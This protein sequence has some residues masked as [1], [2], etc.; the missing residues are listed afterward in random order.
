MEDD[1]YVQ[2]LLFQVDAAFASTGD[3]SQEARED[4]LL[5]LLKQCIDA[6]PNG[7][8]LMRG[9]TLAFGHR[10]LNHFLRTGKQEDLP[11]IQAE[12]TM[13][14]VKRLQTI[15]RWVATALFNS[16]TQP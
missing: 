14:E 4:K 2:E 5:G 10:K 3:G 13:E 16:G 11:R 15:Q 1:Q 9:E 6:H 8:F 7:F 12:L